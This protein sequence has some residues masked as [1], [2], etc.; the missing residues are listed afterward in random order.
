MKQPIVCL[1][2]HARNESCILH[3]DFLAE[4]KDHGSKP[5]DGADNSLMHKVG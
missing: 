2:G 3:H 1:P 5:Q 4:E